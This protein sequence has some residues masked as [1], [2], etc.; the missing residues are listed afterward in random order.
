MTHKRASAMEIE[1]KIMERIGANIFSR[2]KIIGHI[3]VIT[4]DKRQ[5]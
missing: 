1:R 2:Q 3:L 4:D 5:F